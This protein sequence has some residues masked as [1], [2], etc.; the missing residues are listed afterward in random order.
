MSGI[1]R[2]VFNYLQIVDH[3][4]VYRRKYLAPLG[5]KKPEYLLGS[6]DDSDAVPLKRQTSG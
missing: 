4:D 6:G 1:A 3:I 2:I 5:Y